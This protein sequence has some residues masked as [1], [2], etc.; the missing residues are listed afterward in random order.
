MNYNEMDREALIAQCEKLSGEN[1]LL[2]EYERIY[3]V[4]LALTTNT[5][6]VVDIARHAL[7][8]IYNEGEWNGVMQVMENAP[9]SIIETGIIHPDDVQGYRD[10][11]ASIYSGEPTAEFTFRVMGENRGYVYFTM[12]SKTV[13]HE[14]GTPD[15]AIVFSEDVTLRKRAEVEYLN[16]RDAITHDADFVWEAN[17]T[18]DT[19]LVDSDANQDFFAQAEFA[20]YSEICDRAYEN[21]PEEFRMV[22]KECFSRESLL[23]AYARAHR[24]VRLEYPVRLEST[25]QI[26][27]L[28]STAHLISNFE[29]ELC[30]IVCSKDI[31]DRK[32]KEEEL[33]RLAQ[34]DPL[35]GLYNRRFFESN[36]KKQLVSHGSEEPVLLIIDVDNFKAINDRWGHIFGDA[37]LVRIADAMLNCFRRS[38]LLAR[39]G[40]DEYMVYLSTSIPPEVLAQKIRQL[41]NCLKHVMTP[42]GE[43]INICLSIGGATYSNGDSFEQLYRHADIAL[44]N[45]KKRG[46]DQYVAYI[47]SAADAELDP[48][49]PLHVAPDIAPNTCSRSMRS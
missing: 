6:T 47:P 7:I 39:V 3:R 21:V 8:Q 10:F 43:Y 32:K 2:R 26:V 37:V 25:Q 22:V 20:S 24:E 46:K 1:N 15:R 17:L 36:I 30:A 42:D 23:D 48:S 33:M 35:C 45:A 49:A 38:D 29:G 27:W 34:R 40:G 18:Q 16:Y 11:Y 5:V 28:Q 14:D 13:Y 19:M 9:E 4:A 12:Y 41:Q 44:Y 31:S